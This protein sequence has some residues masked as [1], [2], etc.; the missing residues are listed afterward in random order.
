M[1]FTSGRTYRFVNKYFSDYALNVYGTNA[2]S[3]GRN[4][5]LYE[6]TPSDIMQ[7][8]VVKTT[9]GNYFRMHSAVNNNFVLDCSDGSLSNSYQ[10][11]AH[12][13]SM[14]Q[15]TLDDC[16]VEFIPA[17]S[18]SKNIY[19]IRL[20]KSKLCLTATNTTLVNGLPASSIS[21]STALS[22]GSGGHSNVYWAKEATSGSTSTKQQWIVSP[23]VDGES[24]PYAALNWSYIFEDPTRNWGYWGYSP[25]GKSNLNNGKDWIHWGIDIIINDEENINNPGI[26]LLAPAAAEVVETGSGD[27]RGN[28]IVLKMNQLD[29]VSGKP[30][31]V[32]FLHMRDPALVTSGQV[33]KNKLLGYVG[34]SGTVVPHLHLDINIK[35]SNQGSGRGFTASNTINPVRLF[36]NI[37]FPDNYYL[38]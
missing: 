19:K 37:S 24:D 11:N 18:G 29:P 17:T 12:L 34:N 27:D 14:T 16:Q 13:C 28:Y 25:T 6:D 35:D 8:W 2:A 26:K 38:E 3:T 23:K 36:P 7:K 21:S 1:G 31:Y 10:Y 15:T 5:C 33:T 20:V 22:G 9:S 4:V 30:M 32:R